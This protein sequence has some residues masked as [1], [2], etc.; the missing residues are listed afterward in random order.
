MAVEGCASC[1]GAVRSTHTER[2][3]R[4]LARKLVSSSSYPKVYR[5]I[6]KLPLCYQCMSNLP[7]LDSPLCKCCGRDMTDKRLAAISSVTSSP[8][9]CPDCV[10]IKQDETVMNRSFVRYTG[11]SRELISRYKYRGDERLLELLA[12]F[13]VL[14]YFRFY[15]QKHFDAIT[16]VPLHKERLRERGFNQAERL[17]ARLG[18]ELKIPV[19]SLLER[20]KHTEKL[21]KQVGRSARFDSMSDAFQLASLAKPMRVS[22]I[23]LIDDIYTTGSTIRSCAKTIVQNACFRETSICSLTISR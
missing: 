13:L 18:K 12:T 11:W 5:F 16:Y 1:G 22:A 21:S 4:E 14:A 8:S 15:L 9:V 23:L 7:I 6:K 19:F 2:I 20:V 10:L 3:G 17:A